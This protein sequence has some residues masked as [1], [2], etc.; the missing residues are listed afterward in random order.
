MATVYKMEVVD[1]TAQLTNSSP[2]FMTELKEQ[3]K[4]SSSYDLYN[5]TVAR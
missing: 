3:H 2:V 5:K 4:E 1:L